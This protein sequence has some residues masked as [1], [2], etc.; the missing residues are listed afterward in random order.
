MT[1]SAIPAS[2]KVTREGSLTQSPLLST[3]GNQLLMNIKKL[4]PDHWAWLHAKF[5][6]L[7]WAVFFYIYTPSKTEDSLGYFLASVVSFTVILGVLISVVGLFRSLSKY[8]KKAR[9]GLNIELAGLWLAISGP[10]SYT[11]TQ[12]SFVFGPEGDQRIALTALGYAF[13]SFIFV[14][15]VIVR[16]HRKRVNP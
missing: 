16:M 4:R 6:L 8:T 15:I 7:I 9:I 14:R 13:V 5:A 11:V 3:R 2:N 12:F 1:F 10:L